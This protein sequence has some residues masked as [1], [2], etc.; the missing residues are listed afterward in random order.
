MGE[1][2]TPDE[3]DPSPPIFRHLLDNI[4]Q[5][6]F[7]IV[8]PYKTRSKVQNKLPPETSRNMVSKQP[9]QIETKQNPIS[10]RI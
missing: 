5:A 2:E 7:E 1:E 3:E 6:N 8:H 4:F 9:K 10:H